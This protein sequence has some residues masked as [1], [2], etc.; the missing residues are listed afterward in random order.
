M[1]WFERK[2]IL[3]GVSYFY[4]C[5]E[6]S[7]IIY[8]IKKKISESYHSSFILIFG[9]FLRNIDKNTGC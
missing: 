1:F 8:Y 6:Y 7:L 5:I 2:T 9:Y 3:V 4:G